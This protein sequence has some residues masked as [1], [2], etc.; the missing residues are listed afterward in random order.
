[1]KS[2]NVTAENVAEIRE[3]LKEE[4]RTG[5]I[6]ALEQRNAIAAP[7]AN[8][9]NTTALESGTGKSYLSFKKATQLFLDYM[10]D[11]GVPVYEHKNYS[12]KYLK[13]VA[14]FLRNFAIV[15]KKLGH[16]A[17]HLPVSKIGVKEV[18]ALHTFYQEEL[19]ED[20][21]KRFGNHSYNSGMSTIKKLFTYLIEDKNY[22][23]QNPF[24]KVKQKPT[25]TNE[26]DSISL[27]EFEALI[28]ATTDENGWAV[29]H[30]RNRTY[31]MN[32]YQ[33]WMRFAFRLALETGERRD[34]IAHMRWSDIDMPN[35]LI[36]IRNHKV[37]NMKK[38][39]IM[40]RIPITASLMEL[41]HDMG[42]EENKDSQELLIAPD[43]DNRKTVMDKMSKAFTHFLEKAGITKD[44][45][46]KHMRKTYATL[47]FKYFGKHAGKITGQSI[48]TIINH[49]LDKEVIMIQARELSLQQMEKSNLLLDQKSS[50]K[51]A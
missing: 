33:D 12:D 15:L 29:K 44:I 37:S 42:Y 40:R 20:G 46:F 51:R 13:E 8:A 47:M 49:Y 32:H 10:A 16:N 39:K 50:K 36:K 6:L 22:P 3:M 9:S 38:V 31:N 7:S 1:M 17:A 28:N 25:V 48:E 26:I 35:Y 4:K 45:S 34:G 30:D 14:R 5:K 23:L 18:S 41:L 11:V 24:D 43:H 19:N 21:T 2:L 27:E